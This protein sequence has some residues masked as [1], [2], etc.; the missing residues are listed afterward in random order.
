ML[1]RS[2]NT[3]QKHWLTIVYA[4]IIASF[5]VTSISQTIPN[6]SASTSATATADSSRSKEEIQ[7]LG[8][9]PTPITWRT[10]FESW[11]LPESQRA[12]MLGLS[13][14]FD[15][16]ENVKLGV[17]SYG[18]LTGQYGG[19]MTLGLTGELQY[20]LTD[21]WRLRG[22]LFVGGGGGA[23]GYNLTGNGFMF[24][25]DGGLTYRTDG[26]GNIGVGVSWVTFP[27]GQI[28]TVQPYLLY[29]YP[30]YS[31]AHSGWGLGTGK[32]TGSV[33]ANRQE[34]AISWSTYQV[35]S[36]VTNGRGQPQGDFQLVGA[37]WT[38]YLDDRWFLSLQGEGA[39]RAET[40]GYI[41]ILG[42]A[43]YR[44]PLGSMT[45]IK[46][47]GLAG[48]GGAGGGAVD[49]GGGLLLGGGIALQQ[50]LTDHWGLEINAGGMKATTGDFKAWSFGANL[51]YAFGT[52]AVKRNTSWSNIASGYTD[53]PLQLRVM[54]QTFLKASDT[55][56]TTDTQASV[57]NLGLALDYFVN[58]R[59]YV[60]GQAMVA[61]TGYSPSNSGTTATMELTGL[62]GLGWHQ[63]VTK[64]WFVLAEALIGA[65]S[66]GTMNTGTGTAFGLS[67]VGQLNAGVG[68]RVTDNLSFVL[69]GGRIQGFNGD[70]KANVIGASMGYRFGLPTQ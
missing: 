50:M 37:R 70:F 16:H 12:G 57:N 69:T 26:Y 41:Q 10:T 59:F 20:D 49:T 63:P 46:I 25:A 27:T 64:D 38:S 5:P 39:T 61:Y 1:C 28:R 54:N 4:S 56:R 3:K 9:Q 60:T 40:S 65:S 33:P 32:G 8:V 53:N 55:W 11:R 29:E 35:P 21:A 68:Y 45:G 7:R 42:G 13:L 48:S 23:G 31:A 52:P 19:L 47:Y 24:R 30:F 22:G 66:G 51:T 34:V 58:D 18:A 67:G 44:L 15:V 36:S 43:G 62:V 14:L 17:G 6:Q 2:K